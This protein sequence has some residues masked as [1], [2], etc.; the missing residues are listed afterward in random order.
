MK[1][2]ELISKK[3]SHTRK[4]LGM[5]QS[6]I[7]RANSIPQS[8]ISAWEKGT[9]MPPPHYLMWLVSVGIDLNPI[10]DTKVSYEE[11]AAICNKT[12]KPRCVSCIEKESLLAE[13]D[14]ILSDRDQRIS[15]LLNSIRSK[16]TLIDLLQNGR[17]DTQHSKAG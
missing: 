17:G 16:D 8:N 10:L 13:K 9:R 14:K 11:Y 15:E 3:L 1:D 2:K 4:I 7:A 5:T 6:E 12:A